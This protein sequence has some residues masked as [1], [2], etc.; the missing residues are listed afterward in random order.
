MRLLNYSV[1]YSF[2]EGLTY[3]MLS[4][5]LTKH[6]INIVVLIS[7]FV[8]LVCVTRFN[9]KNLCIHKLQNNKNTF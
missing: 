4:D 5:C 3:S 2:K 8:T 9:I 7:H 6:M 1:H